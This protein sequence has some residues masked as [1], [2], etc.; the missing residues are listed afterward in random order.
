MTHPDYRGLG[1]FVTLAEKTY[2]AMAEAGS[3]LVW[4]FP[5]ANSHRGF[6]R[7]LQWVDVYEIPFFRKPLANS[8]PLSAPTG[9]I[10][11]LKRV[12]DRF[13]GLWDRVKQDYNVIV[14]RDRRYL[15]WRYMD[16]PSERYRLLAYLD[17]ENVSGYAV[18]KH[19]KDEFQIVDMLTGQDA[20][21]GMQLISQ[22]AQIAAG[23]SA[24]T[25]SMWLSVTH[26]LHRELERYG[27]ANSEPITYFGMR[28][29]TPG[30]PEAHIYNYR[31]WYVT[32]GDSDV[33]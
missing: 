23:E 33:F 11:E 8:S 3:A 30:I 20:E 1:L 9:A 17:G 19:Y 25:L 14:K 22:T 29:L 31:N 15:Q 2:N 12:D 16:N 26:P 13:D 4:G 28:A 21:I 6:V 32:M 5:N 10:V 27:F 7:D 18:F 24:D